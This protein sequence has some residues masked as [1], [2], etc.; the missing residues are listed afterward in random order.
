MAE[1]PEFKILFVV[2]RTL[3]GRGNHRPSASAGQQQLLPPPGSSRR[4][5]AVVGGPPA[6][7]Q[8]PPQYHQDLAYYDSRMQQQPAQEGG[9]GNASRVMEWMLDV[10]RQQQQLQ[11]PA[12]LRSQSSKGAT[13]TSPRY[14][15]VLIN[16]IPVF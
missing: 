15:A 10:E 4:L 2:Y 9:G 7:Q 14:F 1:T 11:M 12:D 3:P 16:L 8:Q 5:L 13:K 6:N